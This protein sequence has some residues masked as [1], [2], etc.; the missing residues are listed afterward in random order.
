MGEMLKDQC[1]SRE[2]KQTLDCLEQLNSLEQSA[3]R[4]RPS[5]G[6]RWSASSVHTDNLFIF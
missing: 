3:G 4:M 1:T 6:F 2:S 5:L